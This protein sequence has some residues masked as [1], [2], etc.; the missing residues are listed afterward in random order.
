MS[1]TEI[2]AQGTSEAYSA[3]FT[4]T[5]G[6]SAT[7]SL[8]GLTPPAVDRVSVKLQYKSSAGAWFDFAELTQ[9]DPIRSIDA[10]GTF[11]AKRN[12]CTTAIG[13]DKA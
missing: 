9:I 8:T 6:D 2:I 12:A 11:R 13:V 3:E 10:A 4:L 7:I 1:T 5:A